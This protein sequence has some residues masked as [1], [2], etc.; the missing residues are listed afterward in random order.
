MTVSDRRS[1]H[2]AVLVAALG[3]FVDVYDL[4]LFSIVRVASLIDLGVPQ[5]EVLSVGVRLINTQMTG[6]LIGGVFWGILAD[7]FGRRSVLFGSILMY[8]VANI[9]NGMV[10]TVDQYALLRFIA[11]IG[12][13][14]ELGAGITLVAEIMSREGRGWGTTIVAS[15]G[16]LGAVVAGLV[17]DLF[18]WRVAYFVGGG[19]GLLLLGLR[20]GVHESSM[21]QT[22]KTRAVG[23]GNFFLLFANGR[24]ALRY[25]AVV[26]VGLPTWFVMGILI[27]FSPEIGKA[28]GLTE[29][30]SAGRAVMF[31][32]IGATLGDLLSGFLSQVLRSRKKA[33]FI[34]LTLCALGVVNYFVIGR[35]SLPVFYLACGLVG[36]MSGYWAVFVTVAS[37]QFGTNLR[38]TVASTAPN[39]VRGAVV[40]IT[41]LFQSLKPTLGIPGSAMAVG[42]LTLAIGYLS[43]LGLEETF[44]KDLDYVES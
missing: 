16:L 24:R 4:L 32:Y 13:A 22:I 17:G 15:L 2:L 18:P 44:G 20:I 21:F 25:L 28:I 19:L 36:A 30:P 10:Q 38:G 39:F 33:I 6:L 27:T 3:Y 11:G 26:L 35:T 41:L 7:N 5:A 8:S 9:A 42:A 34:F 40:P 1:I 31:A 14:G 12:L 37:E 23:K 43:L 29:A